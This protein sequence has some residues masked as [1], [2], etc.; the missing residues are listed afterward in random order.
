MEKKDLLNKIKQLDVLTNDEKAYLVDLVNT[1]K[2]Y[3]LVWEDKPEDVEEQLRTQLPVLREIV[4]RRILI[5]DPPQFKKQSENKQYSFFDNINEHDEFHI[6]SQSTPNHLIIEGD[7]LHSLTTLTY[8]HEG[9]IDVIYI[10]PPYNTGKVDEFQYNDKWVDAEDTYRHSKWLSFMKKRI[11]IAY[12][13]LSDVGVLFVSIDDNEVAQLKM[14]L[15]EIFDKTTSNPKNSNCFGV[16][17]WDLG[18][19]T[20]AG[21]FTR[22]NEFILAYCKNRYLLPNF[23]GGEGIIDDRAQKK[24]SI[25]NPETEF[26]FPA[27]TKV[28]ANDGFELAGSWGGQERSTL[29]NGR[30]FCINGM[31][32]SPVTISA[33]WTQKRQMESFFAGNETFDSKGQKIVEFYFKDN[34]KIHCRKERDKINPPSVFR[35]IATTKQG[36]SAL[37]EI[38]GGE[39]P[40]KFVKPVELI[41]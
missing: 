30:F 6:K 35:N 19:G 33:G 13:L 37:K 4:E 20:S 12:K 15:D 29:V 26:T 9:A 1:K 39:E 21:H 24:I 7:N 2:K 10:D 5:E 16:L 3:G 40:I 34:G 14:L 17:V 25:K 31:L 32:Q 18:T 41:K 28:E 22:S 23:S 27:G 38:F 11:S 8:S 36:S